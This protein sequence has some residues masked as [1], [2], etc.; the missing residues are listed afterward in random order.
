MFTQQ[1][2]ELIWDMGKSK[3]YYRA[4]EEHNSNLEAVRKME[5]EAKLKAEE[6]DLTTVLTRNIHLWKRM[7]MRRHL[8]KPK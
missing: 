4:V 2:A 8:A 3:G 6:A 7:R 1:G 5:E